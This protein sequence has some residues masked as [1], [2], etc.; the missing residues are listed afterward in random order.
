MYRKLSIEIA[1]SVMN[2]SNDGIN[3]VDREGILLYVNK[4]SADYAGYSIEEM[5]GKHISRYYPMA[6]LLKVLKDRQPILEKRIHYVKSKR[7]VVNSYPYYLQGEFAGAFSIFRS[8]KEIDELNKK[9]KYL[10]L[11]LELNSVVN[12]V[13]SIIGKDGSLSDVIKQARRTVGSLGGP[14]HSIIIGESGTGKTMVASM[15]YNYAKDIG[16]ISQDAPY[17]EINCAQFTNSD[18]AAVEIFGSEEG[19]YTGSKRKKGL[20]EQANGGILFLDEAHALEHYQ[21]L[22]LKAIETGKVRRVGGSREH[23][24]NV[25]VIAA[26]TRNLKMELLPELYQRLA[27]YE[28]YIPSLEERKYRE[29][30]QL[31]DYFVERY[32]EAVKNLHE[33]NYKVVIPP[34]VREILLNAHYP[35]NIRQMRDVINYS[36]DSASPL[37][38]DIDLANDITTTVRLKDLPFELIDREEGDNT[39]KI[40]KT[41]ERLIDN[42]KTEG[43]GARRISKELKKIGHNIEYYQVAY[44][45]KKKKDSGKNESPF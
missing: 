21:N 6:V 5:V 39:G 26:S 12:S 13:Q 28:I 37:I 41:V 8:V 35:R 36:I 7:Y 31:L 25:I 44:F 11:Q 18:I 1:D 19:A 15:I 45:M 16:V 17:I 23:R 34:E 40:D 33:I 32:Q 42:Y 9:I 20:F 24:V 29:K 38:D 3:V 43:M 27:Q 30:S 4:V 14:R 10:E 2:K 22:L